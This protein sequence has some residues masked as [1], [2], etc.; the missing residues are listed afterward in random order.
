M[1]SGTRQLAGPIPNIKTTKCFSN[2]V[3]ESAHFYRHACNIR[4]K[5][6]EHELVQNNEGK[7]T[8]FILHPLSEIHSKPDEQTWQ[9]IE[10]NSF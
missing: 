6:P 9:Y 1:R 8:K 10:K 3:A 4:T 2:K 5:E 7:Q